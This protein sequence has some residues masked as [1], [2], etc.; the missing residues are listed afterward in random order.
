MPRSRWSPRPDRASSCGASTRSPTG[1]DHGRRLPRTGHT[2]RKTPAC[3]APED[4]E[5]TLVKV[6]CIGLGDIAVKAYLPVLTTQPG[7][8]VH[9][10]TR[11]PATLTRVADSLHIP[12]ERRHTDLSD[13]LAQDL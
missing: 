3:C 8:E 4:P 11:T 7:V 13:L 1:V 9:L 12:A 2:P 10:H 5:E 6:G